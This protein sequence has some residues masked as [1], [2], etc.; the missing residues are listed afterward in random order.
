MK[1]VF[2][3]KIE[4]KLKNLKLPGNRKVI[5]SVWKKKTSTNTANY[6][7]DVEPMQR[8]FRKMKI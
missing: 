7:I 8:S 2:Y 6:F 4:R 5:T 1:C 3:V